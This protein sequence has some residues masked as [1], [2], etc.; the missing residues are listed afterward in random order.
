MKQK[1]LIDKIASMLKLKPDELATAIKAEPDA[2][3]TVAIDET[4][5]VLSTDEVTTLKSNSY[6]DGKKAG[7]E[8]EVDAIKKELSLDFTGKTVKGLTDAVAK[9]ALDDAK[10]EPD[11]KV[12]ELTEKLK[13]AQQTATDLQNKLDEKEGEVSNIKTQSLIV[14]DLPT[15]TTLPADKVLLLMK[16]DGYEYKNEDGKIIWHKDGKALTDK[17]GNN[18][19]T[20]DVATEYITTN[21]LSADGGT[22]GTGGRGGGDETKKA[23][24]YGKKSELMKALKDEF[25]A[26]GK[27]A[28]GDEFNK[29]FMAELEIASKVDGFDVNG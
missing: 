18:L 19:A 25:E 10:I 21:K 2:D 29:K 14:K 12:T 16:A 17:L 22:G 1:E 5:T 27:S 7:V 3:V 26:A 9:K 13:T 23:G 15:N 20:K 6:K 24:V 11:K 4:L 8:M 28:L